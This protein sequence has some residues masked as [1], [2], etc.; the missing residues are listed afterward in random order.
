M[1]AHTGAKYA[2]AT[3]KAPNRYGPPDAASACPHMALMRA[4][5]ATRPASSRSRRAPTSG[6]DASM[7]IG[8]LLRSAVKPLCISAHIERAFARAFLSA[9]Q[10]CLSGNVSARYSAMASVSHTLRS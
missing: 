7:F 6:S 8:Q 4:R 10:S 9:G 2:S 3:V 5:S 1:R